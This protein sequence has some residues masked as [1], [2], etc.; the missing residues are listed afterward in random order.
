MSDLISRQDA[1]D[2]IIK[3][4]FGQANVVQ[5]EAAAIQYIK[6]IPSVRPEQDAVSKQAMLAYNKGYEDGKDFMLYRHAWL[7]TAGCLPDSERRVLCL[8]KTKKGVLNYVIGYW[9]DG[10]WR[11]GMNSNVI[12]W[13]DLPEPPEEEQS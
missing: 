1:I 6:R 13:M 11:C 10:M 12:A 3:S 5:A 9:A 8:T 7:P 2:G 4:C